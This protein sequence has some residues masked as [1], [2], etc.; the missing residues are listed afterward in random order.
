MADAVNVVAQQR[1]VIDNQFAKEG[2]QGAEFKKWQQDSRQENYERAE[3]QRR[4]AT[5]MA[6]V[7]LSKDSPDQYAAAY[8]YWCKPYWRVR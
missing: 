7:T 3:I 6:M 5:H 2:F 4:M 1:R 8:Y